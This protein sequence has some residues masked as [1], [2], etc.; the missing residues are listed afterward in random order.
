MHWDAKITLLTALGFVPAF[1][2]MGK[3]W[4]NHALPMVVLAILAFGL[5]LLRMDRLP[6]LA[7]LRK[8]AAVF[9][10]VLVLQ[11]AARTQ[12]AP[13][14]A[15]NGPVER[16]ALAIRGAV[17]RPTVASIGPGCKPRIRWPGTSTPALSHA[18]PRPGRSSTPTFWRA[19]QAIQFKG[20]GWRASATA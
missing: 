11:T 18:I 14:A 3:G 2:I 8:A 6:D 16:A 20:K 17:E 12:Y 4:P 1:V 7:F 19:P 13:L 9:G 15:D 10:C 5:Q